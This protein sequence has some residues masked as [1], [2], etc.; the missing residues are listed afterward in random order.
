MKHVLPFAIL[1]VSGAL[2]V[3]HFITEHLHTHLA[4]PESTLKKTTLATT[5]LL[6]VG[7]V[8]L[9]RSVEKKLDAEG[10]LYPFVYVTKL[11][12]EPDMTIG[13]F[14][15]VV[16]EPHHVTAPFT[17]QFSV[18]PEYLAGLH[19]VGFDVLSLANNHSSDFGPDAVLHTKKLCTEDTLTCEGNA[20]TSE[21]FIK[22]VHG[23]HIGFLVANT[24]WNTVS[25]ESLASQMEQL[26][27]ESDI[28]VAFLHWGTEYELMHNGVQEAVAHALID[29]G[30]DVII[31]GHSHV[32]QDIAFYKD[33]P[34]FYSLGNFVFDQYWNADVQTGLGVKMD[35]GKGGVTYTIIPFTS[36]TSHTQ[37]QVMSDADAE[38]LLKRILPKG[39]ENSFSAPY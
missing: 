39:K 37:P 2:F 35:I 29:A 34:V 6:F 15:G 5:T 31:G 33:K 26:A 16:S 38:V 25:A 24:T 14:E 23:I 19:D 3:P 28:Q 4:A 27:N 11:L 21:T 10:P 7:D 36:F 30:A 12:Q 22:E 18:K 8:M 9:A 1:F 13:N 17:F 32:V 20:R